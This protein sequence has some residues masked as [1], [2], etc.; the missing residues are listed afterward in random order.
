VKTEAIVPAQI[1]SRPESLA[2]RSEEASLHARRLLRRWAGRRRFVVLATDFGLG[3]AFLAARAAWQADSQRC[4]QLVFIALAL[5]PPRRDD[6]ARVHAGASLEALAGELAEAWPPLTPN[7]HVLDFDAGRV[8]LLLALGAA[9]R[10][11]PQLAARVDAFLLEEVGDPV[12]TDRR[13]FAGLARLAQPDASLYSRVATASLRNGLA[14]AGFVI[15]ANHGD[16]RAP[17][18]AR[19]TPHFT[20]RR[21]PV[22]KASTASGSERSAVIVGA[23]IAGACAAAALARLGWRCTV[24]DRH[25]EPA[26]AASGN[27]AALF[28]GTAHAADGVHARL[29][30]AAALL[31]A[32]RYAPLIATGRV[33]GSAS[34][35][36][37]AHPGP[38][39][40]GLPPE[41]VQPGADGAPALYPAAGWIAPRDL[42]RALL[43]DP[44][45]RF[46]AETPVHTIRAQDGT[47]SALDAQGQAIA[48]APVL[49]LA[50]AQGNDTLVR[51]AGGPGWPTRASRGQVTWFGTPQRLERPITGEGYAVTLPGGDVL[52]GATAQEN[53][54]DP[55]VREADHV[56][57]LARLRALTGIVPDPGARLHG[58]VAWRSQTP[59]RLPIVGAVALATPADDSA[60]R[61]DRPRR[62]PRLPGLF[63]LGGLGSRGLTWGPLAGE[64]LAAWI[65]GAP[66]P[67]EGDLVDAIDPARWIV[68]AA[69][70]AGRVS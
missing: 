21:S 5:H 46:E 58:R 18:L 26:F 29:H 19:Y 39:W 65:D 68:R 43:G 31:A 61:L 4:E 32:R 27:R 30:R 44:G 11:L 2:Q 67:L 57:N 3:H 51:S 70:S 48:R 16:G 6:L 42:V 8:R 40:A 47:W 7:I 12:P 9:R 35:L 36:V 33:A 10:L 22:R 1:G 62:V 66:M 14:S 41:Y 45:I 37:R 64:V 60:A 24:L 38:T 34:G 63:V 56:F 53:D 55:Q 17:T 13:F 54:T 49:V 28:H 50:G 20:P 52:C 23:G 25:A 59:D 69:R 15:E